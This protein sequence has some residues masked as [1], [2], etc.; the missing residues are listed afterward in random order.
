MGFGGDRME[1]GIFGVVSLFCIL[2]NI[3]SF[4]IF[5]SIYSFCFVVKGGIFYMKLYD[6]FFDYGIIWLVWLI[7]IYFGLILGL[8]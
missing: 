4:K 1:I 6:E 3:W 8:V 2:G 5:L 7:S